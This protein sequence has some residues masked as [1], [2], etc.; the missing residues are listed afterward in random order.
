MT[1]AQ[2][3]VL[4]LP[5]FLTM[6]I[7]FGLGVIGGLIGGWVGHLFVVRRDIQARNIQESDIRKVLQEEIEYNKRIL[8]E[9]IQPVRAQEV[10]F[11]AR[12]LIYNAEGGF[13]TNVGGSFD[14]TTDAHPWRLF[15]KFNLTRISMDAWQS[16]MGQISASLASD[17][18]AKLFVFYRNLAEIQSRHIEYVKQ[19]GMHDE[20]EPMQ[21]V[22]A[23]MEETVNLP[24]SIV[25]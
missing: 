19:Q 14:L 12:G 6:L 2:W 8:N 7:S 23:L 21:I 22:L 16:Q 5:E 11:Y 9:I 17:E 25:K 13:D 4:D 3:P 20:D 15:K 24:L 10:E 1:P 18:L